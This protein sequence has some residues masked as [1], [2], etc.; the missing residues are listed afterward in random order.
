MSQGSSYVPILHGNV[1]M[2]QQAQFGQIFNNQLPQAQY[3]QQLQLQQQQQLPQLTQ[4]PGQTYP[5]HN[6]QHISVTVTV[7]GRKPMAPV[8]NVE[9]KP[10][11]CQA[12]P[13]KRRRKV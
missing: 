7:R 8:L 9:S 4:L 10:V 5:Q 11:P 2:N 12:N 3:A 6:T 1:M 13:P